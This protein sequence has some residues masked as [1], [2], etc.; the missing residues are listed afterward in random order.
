MSTGTPVFRVAV[1]LVEPLAAG[2]AGVISLPRRVDSTVEPTTEAT[3]RE[4][5]RETTI[6]R[7]ADEL[8]LTVDQR[9]QIAPVLED[10]RTRMSEVF[11]QVRPEYRRVVD[12]ARARIESVLT[13]GQVEMY[14]RLLE[15]ENR[16]SEE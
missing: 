9:E 2:E 3:E 15:S 14:R 13:P 7:F 12:S 8:G 4:G 6:E 5:R 11:D 1:V 16:E 10:T